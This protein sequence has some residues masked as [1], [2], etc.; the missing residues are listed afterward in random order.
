[1]EQK[2]VPVTADLSAVPQNA[3]TENHD[4]NGL[5]ASDISLYETMH[6]YDFLVPQG[7]ALAGARTAML[8]SLRQRGTMVHCT[9]HTA[10][11]ASCRATTMRILRYSA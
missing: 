2:G 8:R 6:D 9:C 7:I 3:P 10:R 11:K 5:S 4:I 1:M